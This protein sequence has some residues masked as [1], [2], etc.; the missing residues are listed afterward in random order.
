MTPEELRIACEWALL[1]ELAEQE[2]L[3]S[4]GQAA[5]VALATAEQGAIEALEQVD[6][7]NATSAGEA[8]RLG[9]G[10]EGGGGGEW[11]AIKAYNLGFGPSA[12]SLLGVL[13]GAALLLRN[14]NRR[15]LSKLARSRRSCCCSRRCAA[16]RRRAQ[17]ALRRRGRRAREYVSAAGQEMDAA[18]LLLALL[19]FIAMDCCIEPAPRAR[20]FLGLSLLLGLFAELWSRFRHDMPTEASILWP[21]DRLSSRPS[22]PAQ[23][24]AHHVLRLVGLP[25]RRRSRR[26]D[27]PPAARPSSCSTSTCTTTSC[28]GRC[29]LEIKRMAAARTLQHR[30]SNRPTAPSSP[31]PAST[32]GRERGPSPAGLQEPRFARAS[33]PRK[34]GRNPATTGKMAAGS[35]GLRGTYVFAFS[36]R[37]EFQSSFLFVQM[38]IGVDSRCFRARR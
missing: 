33:L 35:A 9:L 22:A 25:A 21:G 26:L 36:S 12:L 13:A 14:A 28:T 20:C 10:L 5:A 18:F 15:V 8:C 1:L 27:P 37:F 30:Q 3:D 32:K 34:S 19:V 38:L 29:K 4:R 6:L 31:S 7:G 23:A 16:L 2:A 11:S 24:D 17:P